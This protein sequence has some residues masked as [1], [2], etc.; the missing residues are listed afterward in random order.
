MPVSVSTVQELASDSTAVCASA[1]S[2]NVPCFKYELGGGRARGDPLPPT[3][4]RRLVI[5]AAAAYLAAQCETPSRRRDRMAAFDRRFLNVVVLGLGFMFAFTAFQTIGNIEKTILDSIHGDDPS[6]SGDGYSSL[7]IL[8]AVL[9]LSNWLTPSIISVT[10]PRL[11]MDVG[12]LTYGLFIASFLAESTWLLYAASALVGF[13]AALLWTGQGAYLAQNSDPDT[14]SRNS[15]VFWALLQCSMFFG[16][17]FV[18]VA[19]SG[20]ARIA[21]STRRLVFGVLAG[22]CGVGLAMLAALRPA[23]AAPASEDDASASSG[24]DGPMDAFR[25]ALRLAATPQMRLLALTFLY[26]GLELSFYSGVYGASVGFTT[27]L[28]PKAKQLVPLAGIFCG[29]G[30]VAGGVAL[31][32]LGKRATRHGL[33]PGVV[34]SCLLHVAAFCLAFLNLPDA[35][36]FKDTE[37]P[38][39]IN[40]NA[41]VAMACAAL[42]GVGDSLLVTQLYALLGGVWPRD[43]ASAF[44]IFKF[45]QSVGAAASFVY[46]RWLGL[47]AQLGILVVGCA[48]STAA[49]SRAEAS[50]RRRHGGSCADGDDKPAVCS[51]R[52]GSKQ[53]Q[54]MAVL[55]DAE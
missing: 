53:Q 13:G 4:A 24:P 25:G 1:P 3:C 12:A 40:S 54:A 48:V 49:F 10:G 23:P 29:A 45:V 26:S 46:S 43:C 21:R 5:G 19:F 47:H 32:V 51:L 9:S 44:A 35:A 55:C 38:A 31:G 7:A 34:V 18:Y 22:V 8:Y 30:E 37:D 16:N 52:G 41:Y 39:F 20:A 15:A 6:F 33:F 27:R 11:A 36:P 28:G 17:L 42:L 14:V 50:L 2:D